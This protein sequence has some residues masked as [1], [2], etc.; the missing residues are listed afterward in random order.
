MSDTRRRS[1]AMADLLLQTEALRKEFGGLVAV[2]DVDFSIPRGAII[3]LI[4]PNGAGKTTFF[5]ML[6]GVYMPTS[7]TVLFDGRGHL[8]QAAA[9][10]HRAGDRAHVPEHPPLR[11]DDCDRERPRRHAL[12]SQE[13][14]SRQHRSDP[15]CEARGGRSRAPA[16][17]SSSSTATSP[18]P[19][20][21]T[22]AISRTATNGGSRWHAPS[23]PGPSCSSWTSPRPA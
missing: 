13:R 23:P 14:D 1:R 17:E 3:S 6:T 21:S 2:N 8:R 9:R 10:G 5:N 12:S 20:T 16:P 15:R 4:G 11:P 18:G 19:T 7:G 22:H